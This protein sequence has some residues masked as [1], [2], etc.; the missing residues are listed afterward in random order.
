MKIGDIAY[1][2]SQ[3]HTEGVVMAIDDW[4]RVTISR[5][6]TGMFLTVD[7][8]DLTVKEECAYVDYDK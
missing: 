8:V 5:H 1:L 7:M 4:D 2:K 3:P 6:D